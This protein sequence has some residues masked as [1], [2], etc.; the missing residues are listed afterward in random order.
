MQSLDGIGHA[1]H[2]QALQWFLEH[3]GQVMG[4]PSD[5]VGGFRLANQPK[6]IYKPAGLP[7]ALSIKLVHDGPYADQVETLADGRWRLRYAGER[8]GDSKFTNAGLIRCLTDGVPVGVLQRVQPSAIT[9]C[10]VVE[11]LEAAHIVP[12]RGDQTNVVHNG[13]LLRADLHTL[14]DLGLLRIDPH[15]RQVHLAESA[16]ADYPGL[17]GCALRE[18]RDASQRP[19]KQALEQRWNSAA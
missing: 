5:V 15:T 3:A 9:G 1:G 4:W 12:Y 10:A 18:P 7:Y 8:G 6:G 14:F 2:R 11:V 16:R 19:S 17:H 13:L